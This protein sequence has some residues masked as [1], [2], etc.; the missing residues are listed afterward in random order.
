MNEQER[1]ARELKHIRINDP[2]F[3]PPRHHRHRRHRDA[4]FWLW[5]GV[6]FA[7]IMLLIWLTVAMFTG[8]TDVN[9]ITP[10][11]WA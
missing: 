9:L 2:G 6:G 11:P 3:V 7:I 4:S 5:I 10:F 8:D 1:E